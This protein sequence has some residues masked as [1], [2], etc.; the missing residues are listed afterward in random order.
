MKPNQAM[1]IVGDRPYVT[2][3]VKLPTRTLKVRYSFDPDTGTTDLKSATEWFYINGDDKFDATPGNVEVGTPT[4]VM[5][6]FHVN[7]LWLQTESLDLSNRELT[8][9]VCSNR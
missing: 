9:K 8:L 3:E 4:A 5:P 1:V 6:R 7:D 2:G